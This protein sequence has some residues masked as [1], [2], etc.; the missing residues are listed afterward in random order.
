M[1]DLKKTNLF[2]FHEKK[3]AKFV[4][5]AGYSM[6]VQYKSG[7]ISEHLHTRSK[8]G[9][10][11]VSHMGQIKIWPKNNE[12]EKLIQA[13]EKL[14][15]CDLYNLKENRQTYSLL[16]NSNGG[17]IDDLMIA[18]KVSYFQLVVNASQ[19]K[20]DYQHLKNNISQD[21]DIELEENKSLLAI[22]GP[23]SENILSDINSNVK[24]MKFMD[25]IDI[26][27]AG[28]N[29]SI[30]RSGYTGEDGFEISVHNKNVLQLVEIL[31][32]KSELLPIGLG[33]RDSLRLEAGLCLYG[34]DLTSDITPIEA[35]LNWVIHKRRREQDS[36]NIKF[37]G[38]TKILNQLEKGPS[39]LRIGLLPIEKAPMRR[40]SIIYLDEGGETEIGIV[41]SGGY[42]PTL[43]KPISMGRLKS[44]Y[45]EGLEKVFV[46]IRDKILPAT[47]T[48]LPFIKTKY[49]I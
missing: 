44:E 4:P 2:D 42:S 1:K 32:K 43:N 16:T 18:N 22:Q 6:P 25:S 40:E 11:D 15:P 30:S 36:S 28:I 33:A 23:Q 5:F 12:K 38:N 27:L 19:K 20:T 26:S 7:V 35:N 8:A 3:G 14:M 48:K 9:F 37:L 29:C 47:I 24:N 31:F 49:K 13:L 46:K 45:L 34:N 10:F 17:V 39:Y 21:F 41:T